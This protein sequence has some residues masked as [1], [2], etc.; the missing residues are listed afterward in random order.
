MYFM[1]LAILIFGC[2]GDMHITNCT[3]MPLWQVGQSVLMSV[4]LADV[5][6]SL[7]ESEM[8]E[9]VPGTPGTSSEGEV[10]DLAHICLSLI[11]I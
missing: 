8:D 7:A 5:R 2:P 10:F 11:H 6:E 1:K 4:H 9:G 3:R